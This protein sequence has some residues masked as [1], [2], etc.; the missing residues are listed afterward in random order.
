MTDA[1][2][3]EAICVGWDQLG[4]RVQIMVT[5]LQDGRDVLCRWLGWNYRVR[6]E[7]GRQGCLESADRTRQHHGGEL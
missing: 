7:V 3:G 1:N 4:I 2:S 5:L 6:G